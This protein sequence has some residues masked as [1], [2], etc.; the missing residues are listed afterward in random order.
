MRALRSTIIYS[1]SPQ[2]VAMILS[3]R[4]GKVAK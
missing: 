4:C 3:C 2:I 1:H